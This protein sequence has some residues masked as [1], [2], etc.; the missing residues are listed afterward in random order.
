MRGPAGCSGRNL[1]EGRPGWG[2]KLAATWLI[3]LGASVSSALK[4]GDEYASSA[5]VL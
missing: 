3:I 5:L 2:L 4:Q 1:Q